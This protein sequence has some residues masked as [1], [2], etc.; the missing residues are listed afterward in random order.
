[1]RR[2]AVAVALLVGVG[3]CSGSG[4]SDSPDRVDSLSPAATKRPPSPPTPAEKLGLQAGWGPSAAQLDRAA[5]QVRRLPLPALAGQVIVAEWQGTRAP[6][7]MVRDLHLGGVIAFGSNVSSARQVRSVNRT[8]SRQVRRPWPLFLA[9]DQEGGAV[10]RLRGVATRFPTFM[11]VGAANDP[12]LTRRA[13]RASGAE[14]RRLGFT[15]DFGP[16]ADVTSGP[17]DPTIG[18]R[19]ASSDPRIVARQVIAA[20]DGFSA[21]GIVPVAKH[22]PGHGSVPADSHVTL[23]VQRRSRAELERIDL[24]PF[25]KSVDAGLPAVMIGHLDIRAVD[26]RVPASL[27]RK[28]VTGLL[29]RDLGFGGLVVTDSLSMAAVTRSQSPSRV[30]VRA[31]RAGADVLLMPSSP[32]KARS[33]LVRAVRSG[34]LPRRRLEQA[35]ARQVALLRHLQ[36]SKGKAVGSA[37]KASR[38][39]SASAITIA[40]GP[41]STR[42]V[43]NAVHPYGDPGA[44]GAFV[45]AARRSGL[46]VLLRRTP[47]AALAGSRAAPARRKQ[48]RRGHFRLRRRAWQQDEAGRE[49]RLAA[50]QAREAARVGA[51][52]AVGF[53]GFRGEPVNATVAVATD[54]PWVL[55][56]VSAPVRIATYGDTPGAMWVLVEVLLGRRPAPG[57]LPVTVR[58]VE[59]RGC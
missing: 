26:P 10:E 22:F 13:Y 15:V 5:R 46:T 2:T 49:R 57:R 11:S 35:A 52:T 55:G 17:G 42:L 47:P 6:V 12:A 44:V 40:S 58:G 23:P 32:G 38:Q 39:L 25:R 34:H 48:E 59:R 1:M 56:S 21:A 18:S 19:S 51:G 45:A 30:A 29:R 43:T 9:V 36:D 20:A 53:T 28:V 33:A 37:R 31:I 41:C 27:S 24:V 54:S 8:L 50:W 16:V 3:G 7:G 14:L 4:P